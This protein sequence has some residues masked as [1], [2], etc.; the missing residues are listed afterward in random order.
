M[1]AS[2]HMGTRQ[3]ARRGNEEDMG[4]EGKGKEKEGREEEE[5]EGEERGKERRHKSSLRDRGVVSS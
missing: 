2:L 4:G 1:Y 3:Q 5:G